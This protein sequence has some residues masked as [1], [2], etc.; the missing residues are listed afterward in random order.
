MVVLAR[1]VVLVVVATGRVMPG[2]TG[3]AGMF[4]RVMRVLWVS[5]PL[6]PV[7]DCAAPV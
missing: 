1:V 3:A 7:I 6:V 5:W 4:L 2:L